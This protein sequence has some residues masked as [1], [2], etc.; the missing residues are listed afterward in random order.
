M[1]M[2]DGQSIVQWIMD[3]YI[4][5]NIKQVGLGSADY[6]LISSEREDELREHAETLKFASSTGVSNGTYDVAG[7]RVLFAPHFN[8]E[9]I[10]FLYKRK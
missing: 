5:H 3:M 9:E 10:E 7:M 8:R 4:H 6:I 1:V 2:E